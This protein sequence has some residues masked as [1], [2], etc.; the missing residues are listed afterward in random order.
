MRY[1]ALAIALSAAGPALAGG[2]LIAPG[3]PADR[4]VPGYIGSANVPGDCA[5]PAVFADPVCWDAE[6]MQILMQWRDG[7]PSCMTAAE[8]LDRQRGICRATLYTRYL[9]AREQIATS[10]QIADCA[11]DIPS[12]EEC[13]AIAAGLRALNTDYAVAR[14]EIAEADAAA[15]A[16]CTWE[17]AP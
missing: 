12:A 16:A 10:P 8:L 1:L 5:P 6:G 13:Q 9:A 17:V 7:A 4:D 3:T 2:C 11:L 15:A 14:A